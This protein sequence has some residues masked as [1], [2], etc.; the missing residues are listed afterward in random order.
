[1]VNHHFHL[2]TFLLEVKCLNTHLSLDLNKKIVF[3]PLYTGSPKRG[4]LTNS[5]KMWTVLLAMINTISSVH[6][7]LENLKC[8]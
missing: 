1:M 2:L 8:T 4:T 3:N 5:E 7:Y 6:N